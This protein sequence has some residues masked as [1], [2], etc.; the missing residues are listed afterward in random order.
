[1]AE[2]IVFCVLCFLFYG[3]I[4]G[5]MNQV[6]AVKHEDPVLHR[7]DKIISL[8]HLIYAR[9]SAKSATLSFGEE[10]GMPAS[11]SVGKTATAVFTEWDGP[12]GTGN[13][14]P[15]SGA[16]NYASDNTSVATVDANGVATG[17]APGTCNI[18]GTDSVNGLS[19][20]DSLTVN[21]VAQSATLVLTANP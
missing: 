17:V 7:L 11:I 5:W 1:M 21:A 4:V 15:P 3:G 6:P 8:L 13:K 2:F 9:L 16:V 14:V 10:K 18:S 12:N 19:A 20:S